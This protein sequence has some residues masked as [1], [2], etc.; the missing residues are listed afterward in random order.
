LTGRRGPGDVS[1]RAESPIAQ[2]LRKGI[3]PDEGV[4]ALDRIVAND[5]GPQVIA[6]SVDVDAWA[7]QV[8]READVV[9]LGDG[10]AQ[11][12]RPELGTE[13]EA[14]A[15]A[16]ERQ[17]A[18]MWQELLGVQRVGRNDD[19]FDLG[20]QS[21]VAV[22]L[23]TRIRSSFHVDLP[24][25]TLFEAPT[26]AQCAAVV[27]ER[28]GGDEPVAADAAPPLA[29]AGQP[30]RFSPLVIIQRGGSRL[31]FFCVHGA[32]GNTLNF[33][34]LAVQMGRD[35]PFYGLQ[36]HGVDGVERPLGSVEEMAASYLAEVRTVQAGGPYLLGGYSG[37]GLVAYEM[38]QQLTA[39]GESVALV[40]LLDTLP[41][42]VPAIAQTWQSRIGRISHDP[43][44]VLRSYLARRRAA[45]EVAAFNAEVDAA[46]A[47]GG[48]MPLSLREHHIGRHFGQV[49]RRYVRRPWKGNVTLLRPSEMLY[50]FDRPD[51]AYGW[52]ELVGDGFELIETPGTHQTI[53]LEPNV[54]TLV[55]LLADTLRRAQARAELVDAADG[56]AREQGGPPGRSASATRVGSVPDVL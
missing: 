3:H 40:L 51:E 27:R 38:A 46:L 32:G 16:I 12:A 42:V 30:H 20:G 21:L 39:A 2:A 52:D 44:G 33:R 15:T 6:S 56:M 11:A 7:A 49:A 17:I 22:R 43:R 9:S 36:A 48:E 31:P 14:P 55:Q 23:F 5:L 35:Q 18:A 45:K 41:P 54:G 53:L 4:D 47:A 19:F 34:D 1:A 26:V 50:P 13:F 25:S 29:A 24:L 28:V 8:D 10:S 37:G